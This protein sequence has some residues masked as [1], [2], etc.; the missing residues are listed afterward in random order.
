MTQFYQAFPCISTASDKHW[1]VKAWVQGYM[2]PLD[3]Y[4]LCYKT[5]DDDSDSLTTIHSVLELQ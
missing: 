5:T 3:K 4:L 1:D 2:Q